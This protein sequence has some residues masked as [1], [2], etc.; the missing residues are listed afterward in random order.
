VGAIVSRLNRFEFNTD[1]PSRSM[2]AGQEHAPAARHARAEPGG[3]R[4]R[5]RD[6]PDL[7]RR[8]ALR[9]QRQHRADREGAA[10]RAVEAAQGRVTRAR[11]AERTLALPGGGDQVPCPRVR[12]RSKSRRHWS[13]RLAAG[14][15][16]QRTSPGFG[17]QPPGCEIVGIPRRVGEGNS[18][19][20]RVHSR[21]V[22]AEP[23]R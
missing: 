22:G 2:Q 8:G 3:A 18:A 12:Y 13:P 21:R 4:A 23:L 5:V 14:F 17:R 16:P 11:R 10:H 6:Q 1:A 20:S 19:I 7:P 15:D 9:A